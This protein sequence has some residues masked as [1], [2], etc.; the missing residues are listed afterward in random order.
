MSGADSAQRQSWVERVYSDDSLIT[1]CMPH[2]SL[3]TAED[4]PVL[5]STSS[6]T[7]PSLMARMMEAI[8][9]HDVHRVLEIGT[10]YNTALLCHRLRSGNVVS[11]DIDPTLVAAAKN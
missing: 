11:I 6:S 5:V 9:V 2:P 3:R 1:Q 10:G 4:Q 8:D 7:M